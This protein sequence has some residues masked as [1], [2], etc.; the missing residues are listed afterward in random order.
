MLKA[1]KIFG[2]SLTLLNEGPNL[3]QQRALADIPETIDTVEDH[4]NL[5]IPC[6]T[7][8]LKYN[9]P[10]KTFHYYPFSDWFG[11]FLALP[12]IQE[13]GE[14][15]CE[16]V[17]QNLHP[18]ADKRDAR[19]GTLIRQ[20]Q[21]ADGSSFIADRGNEGRWL[22]VLHADSFNVEGNRIRGRS[23]STGVMAMKCLNL[24]ISM[25]NDPAYVYVPGL[26]QGPN[27]PNA[28]EAAHRHFLRPLITELE[29]AYN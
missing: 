23:S 15:F 9:R 18:P 6:G 8:L 24:P 12:G 5:N 14:T 19:D 27:E 26:I 22:F 17:T 16:E 2:Y 4:F 3:E 20:L 25:R 13:I 28:K 1:L 7:S 11:R 21:S 29:T 10:I